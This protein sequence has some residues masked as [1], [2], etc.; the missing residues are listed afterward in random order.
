MIFTYN[1]IPFEMTKFILILGISLLSVFKT[2][3]IGLFSSSFLVPVWFTFSFHRQ[4]SYV[5]QRTVFI[6]SVESSHRTISIYFSSTDDDVRCPT[7]YNPTLHV[8]G[9]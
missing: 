5:K 1:C 9:L 6:S 8:L 7:I 3:F 4:R 2:S